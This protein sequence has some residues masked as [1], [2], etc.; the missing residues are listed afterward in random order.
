MLSKEL[1][2]RLKSGILD[3]VYLFHGN[4][5]YVKDVYTER[6]KSIVL[7]NDMMEMNY[8]H[9]KESVT[10]EELCELIDS[11]PLMCDKKLVCLHGLGLVKAGLKQELKDAL[12][13]IL[14]DIPPY[15]VL[16]IRED[17]I[18][19]RQ[20]ALL[21]LIEENGVIVEF[22]YLSEH[23]MLVFVNREIGKY[24]KK[25]RKEDIAYLIYLC[26]TSIH[27]LLREVEKLCNYVGE[28]EVI[29]RADIDK[30]V[31][32]SVET[33]IFEL[34]D[35]LIAKNKTLAYQILG[36]LKLFKFQYP[37]AT[38]LSLI[39]RHMTGIYQMKIH[40]DVYDTAAK[41]KYLDGKVPPFVVNKYIK[42]GAALS[43][44]T[45]KEFLKEISRLDVQTKSG[46]MDGYLAVEKLIATF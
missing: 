45:L 27:S 10:K 44:K 31:K 20:K 26:D 29:T 25:M 33:R 40:S 23:D 6:I 32:K 17:S 38:L 16:V 18:D 3:S 35:A 12:M 9:I 14:A 46:G 21:K 24:G 39:A 22:P 4:E 37:A 15:V 43:E 7:A 2:K 28:A 34:S 30:M 36:E 19:K 11:V 41:M 42:Q 5:E 1:D 8:H 13:E